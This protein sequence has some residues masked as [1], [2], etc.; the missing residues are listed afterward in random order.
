[1]YSNQSRSNDRLVIDLTE[2]DNN[3]MSYRSGPRRLAD[4]RQMD[5]QGNCRHRRLICTRCG[6]VQTCKHK[7]EKTIVRGVCDA[8]DGSRPFGQATTR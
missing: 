6:R 8:C 2:Q 3:W 5:D 4:V 1:M 7:T